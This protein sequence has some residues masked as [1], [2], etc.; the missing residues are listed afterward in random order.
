M[1]WYQRGS[2]RMITGQ[3]DS[4]FHLQTMYY[5]KLCINIKCHIDNVAHSLGM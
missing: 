4:G 3:V 1:I 2:S 5:Y